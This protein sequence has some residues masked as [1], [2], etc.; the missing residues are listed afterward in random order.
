MVSRVT[1]ENSALICS[2]VTTWCL[3]NLPLNFPFPNPLGAIIGDIVG[4]VYEWDRIK[5]KDFP[6]FADNGFFTDDS[7]CTVAVADILL[8]DLPPAETLQKWCQDYLGRGYSGNFSRWI[9]VDPP[10][11][12]HSYG[13]GTAMRVSAA[14]FLNR[15]DLTAAF[16]YADVS[17][18]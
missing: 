18:D 9:Y 14:A 4:S 13:N 16:A 2:A 7:V 15:D 10:E 17:G 12:Y 8:H 6:F 3:K 5:T 1:I 11:P